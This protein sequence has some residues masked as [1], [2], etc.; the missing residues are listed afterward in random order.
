M[1]TEIER[2]FLVSEGFTPNG[3]KQI[4]MT[5][6]Y[7][8][9]DPERTVR[10]RIAGEKAF[11]TVKGKMKGISRPEFEYE[12]PPTDADEMLKLA[13]YPVIDKVRHIIYAFGKKWEVDVFEGANAGLIIAEVELSDADENIDLPAWAAKEVSGDMRYHNS[14]LA[15]DPYRNWKDQSVEPEN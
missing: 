13:V 1:A 14:C 12:I 10:I 6:G 9:A 3:E 7:L 15:R 5:Q 8:C 4:R 11:F 2:K